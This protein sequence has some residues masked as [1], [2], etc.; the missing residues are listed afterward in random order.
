MANDPDGALINHRHDQSHLTGEAEGVLS[1]P[2]P[3]KW[4]EVQR[5]TLGE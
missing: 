3:A 4:V 2:V 5:L 1:P